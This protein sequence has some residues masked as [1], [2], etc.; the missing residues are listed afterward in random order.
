M[1]MRV[2][3][4]ALVCALVVAHA[5]AYTVDCNH[6]Y[7]DCDTE[8]SKI[9]N[10]DDDSLSSPNSAS[11]PVPVPR[12]AATIAP[13]TTST[14]DTNEMNLHREDITTK[15]T[16]IKDPEPA[17]NK[18][19][20]LLNL[21]VEDLQSF[22][23]ALHNDTRKNEK[24]MPDLSDV[25]LD[26]DDEESPRMTTDEH[27]HKNHRDKQIADKFYTNLQVPFHPLLSIDRPASSEDTDMCKE[28]GIPYKIGDHIERGCDESC[29]CTLPGIFECSPR[30]KHPY[31]RRGRRL[32]DPLCFESPV[33]E[34]CSIVACATGNQDLKKTL[35]ICKYGNDSYVAGAKWN[36]GCEQQCSCE[37]NSVVMCK[38]RCKK[39][40]QSDQCINV[41][42]PN[43]EC[44]EVQVCDVSHDD[45]EE[46]V[47]NI[48]TTVKPDT[49]T[50]SINTT[51]TTSVTTSTST[52]TESYKGFDD[53]DLQ[54]RTFRPLV[55]P[56]PIGSVK[57]L[58]NNSVQ[59]NLMH[60]NSSRDPIHL[61][62][63]KDGGRN[64]EDVELK[65]SNLI[66]NLEGGKDY[67]LKTKETGTKFNFTITAT[68]VA[69]GNFSSAG[70]FHEGTLYSI[71]EEYH[72]GC[73]ELCECTGPNQSECVELVCPSHVGL[74]LMS[75]GCVRWAPSPPPTPPNCCPRTA[76]CISDGTCHYNGTA[77]PNWTEVPITLTGCEQRCFCEN[78]E[79]D[80]QEVCTPLPPIP[81]QTMR[82]PPQHRPS[83]VNISDDDCCKQWACVPHPAEDQTT[84]LPT[85][86]INYVTPV[87]PALPTTTK[88]YL[89]TVSTEP[90][91]DFYRHLHP[92]KSILKHKPYPFIKDSTKYTAD[93]Q[94]Y[95]QQPTNSSM[96][97]DSDQ[98]MRVPGPKARP[99]KVQLDHPMKVQV[100]QIQKPLQAAMNNAKFSHYNYKPKENY[101]GN[102]R[103]IDNSK[104][105]H[106]Y[107]Y[108][109]KSDFPISDIDMH[110]LINPS[111]LFKGANAISTFSKNN[112]QLP[113]KIDEM[114]P[115]PYFVPAHNVFNNDLKPAVGEVYVLESKPPVA[116]DSP[117][118]RQPYYAPNN[119]R[120]NVHQEPET[121]PSSKKLLSN[122]AN[123]SYK[124][125]NKE[126]YA[127]HTEP[128]GH[129]AWYDDKVQDNAH[130]QMTAPNPYEN[131][132]L[133]PVDR[134]EP[135][136][137]KLMNPQSRN[138]PLDVEHLVNQMEVE[139][140]VNRNLERSADK[141]QNPAAGLT[142]SV[143][144]TQSNHSPSGFLP[145]IPPEIHFPQDEIPDYDQNNLHRPINALP[146]TI[147]GLPPGL[148]VPP[149]YG[150]ENKK[151]SVISLQADSPTSIKLLFGLPP[152]LVGL[153]G[154]VD[155]RY[156]DEPDQD[157]SEWYSQVFAPAD[158]VLTTPR[159]EFRL[160]GLKPSTTYKIRG[161]LY[162]HNLPVEP[163]SDIYSVRTLDMP[164]VPTEEKRREI[165]SRLMVVD[166]ND[167]VAHVS[168]RHFS[169]SELQYI[170]GIQVRYRP[171]GTPIYSMTELLHHSRSVAELRELRPGTQY[172]ASLVLVP[173]P[174]ATTE[175]KDP[176]SVQ[177]DT[178]PYVDPYN[179]TVSIEARVVGSDA[180]E[181]TWH[182]I[183][184]PAE[185]WVRVYRAAHAC[186]TS[187]HE[188]DAFRLATR[189][190]P[191]TIML[192]GLDPDSKC[193]VWM[194]L[195]LTN[196][197]IKTSNVLE[198]NTK[199]Q[200]SPE[201]IDNEIEAS[202]IADS[203]GGGR[204]D[205]YGALVVVGV[206]AALGALTSLLLLLVLV[207]RHRPRS[208]P[209]T[210]VPSAPRESSLPP[211]DNPAYKLELQQETMDL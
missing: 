48:T 139:A 178:A 73:S 37:A 120:H 206:V 115:E 200:D 109:P 137:R 187:R 68:D 86:I 157:I 80:C 122:Q 204:G 108:K 163:Q 92:A 41:Q 69:K 66:L 59:V 14:R 118:H 143:T 72:I 3:V 197:K 172:E 160:T 209:I 101:P 147:P 23:N 90:T 116:A 194:E 8:L 67:I 140:E 50:S 181:L 6:E 81:P 183:P 53:Y 78:G 167:T 99:T 153:R 126:L 106:H 2:R 193:R 31:I 9:A 94:K 25:N 45:H 40:E 164:S 89:S 84:T 156:T 185:R 47:E 54:A 18:Q 34:C 170:D 171:V 64:F 46:P 42:D 83:P 162:L 144:P 205:Y 58:Q 203:R 208:V 173:P 158:E 130:V 97:I 141:S 21:N 26:D 70:C 13:L 176:A 186:G 15:A 132:L 196:G 133:R 88:L 107:D 210:P 199:S 165:D 61:M 127:I 128:R 100:Q 154:S 35:E 65:Y 191:P 125:R 182:G 121:E 124:L 202:S 150:E 33:D 43:D 19:P 51:S 30:C 55:L 138:S 134:S 85:G 180:A 112:Y 148:P 77:I 189:D 105:I 27:D 168:W 146:P 1:T 117:T 177:F 192:S 174:R 136:H 11:A 149:N 114:E 98:N 71:G 184:S 131:V 5:A 96:S 155:L 63:S 24:K 179:W 38:P 29:E 103:I 159:L 32:N 16:E 195:F 79:L 57:V 93:V 142:T 10:D 62:L 7:T 91:I 76:R 52:T 152:V 166:V 190:L 56:E 201:E 111:I 151:L 175:L 207:R 82:C 4:V 74:E 39:L 95:L 145:T 22:A 36:I 198:I 49:T 44:C 75:K 123:P 104:P 113:L 119:N 87:T 169:E 161:K 60:M 135:T 110:E 129:E 17:E 102:I 28:N 12:A 20:R 211:Y 188:H